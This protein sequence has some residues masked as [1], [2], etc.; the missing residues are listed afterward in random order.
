[1]TGMAGDFFAV[2]PAK[3]TLQLIMLSKLK[4]CS[5]LKQLLPRLKAAGKRVVFTNGCFDLLHVGHVHY[6]QKA[7]DCGDVLVIAVNS[8]SSVKSIKGEK[9]PLV[10]ED[11]RAELLAALEMVDFVVIFDQPT[12]AEIIED[13]QPDVLV[14]GGDWAPD[15]I[16]G[17][18][19][20]EAGGGFVKLI[21]PIQGA[22]TTDIVGRIIQRYCGGN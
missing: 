7:K 11:E 6:L 22:S 4:T 15:K 18:E 17:R 9:R 13:L 8:D 21:P 2:L 14:K 16:V 12:P 3:H 20:V 1:M 10:A 19:T 5:Q